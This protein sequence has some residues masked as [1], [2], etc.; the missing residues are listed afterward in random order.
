MF[1]IVAYLRHAEG[2]D[3]GPLSTSSYGTKRRVLSQRT[4][5]PPSSVTSHRPSE[6]MPVIEE[7]LVNSDAFVVTPRP[8]R[9]APQFIK[10]GI[11]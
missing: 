1:E 8:Y 2:A 11:I 4:K 7:R 5:R 6:L 9:P 10:V 3:R